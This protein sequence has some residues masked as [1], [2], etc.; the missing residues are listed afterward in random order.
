MEYWD[1]YDAKRRPLGKTHLRGKPMRAGEYHDVAEIWTVNSR[2]ELLLTLRHP[3]KKQ[4]PNLWENTCGSVLA[5][6]SRID[7]ALRELREETGITVPAQR[8]SLLGSKR[9]ASAFVDSYLLVAD[10]PLSALIMQPGETIDA[11]WVSLARLEKLICACLVAHP[12]TQ[13]FYELKEL[14]LPY[15]APSGKSAE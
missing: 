9:D 3:D 13:R 12:V 11:Q 2:R 1:L 7:G 15:L 6:E 4:F 5:G 8:L 10:I 14:L